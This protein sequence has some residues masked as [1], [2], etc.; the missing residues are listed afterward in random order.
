M[1]RLC[2][3]QY[4][5][6]SLIPGTSPRRFHHLM[7]TT[8]ILRPSSNPAGLRF[9]SL[10]VTCAYT[11][12]PAY[13]AAYVGSPKFMGLPRSPIGSLW[14]GTCFAQKFLLILHA[15]MCTGCILPALS[16]TAA[17]RPYQIS[18]SLLF[19]LREHERDRAPAKRHRITC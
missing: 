4:S 19:P 2:T 3:Y 11:L 14:Q 6:I 17:A 13:V 9:T 16:P 10:G 15:K 12:S 7:L 18:Q 8:D 5:L 1:E